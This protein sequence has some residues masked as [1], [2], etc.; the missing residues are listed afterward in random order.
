MLFAIQ[1]ATIV[2]TSVRTNAALVARVDVLATEMSRL[3][4][5]N[6]EL[7]QTVTVLNTNYALSLQR[8]EVLERANPAGR[9]R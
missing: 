2:I 4:E 1:I 3:V 9:R 5:A 8:I 7:V 6:K